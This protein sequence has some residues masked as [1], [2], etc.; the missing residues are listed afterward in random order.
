MQI[1]PGKL[2]KVNQVVANTDQKMQELTMCL[3]WNSDV[4]TQKAYEVIYMMD[5]YQDVI[6]YRQLGRIKTK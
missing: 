4:F 6:K 5:T 1:I 3:I 2:E